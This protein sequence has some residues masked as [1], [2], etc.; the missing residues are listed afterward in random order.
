MGGPINNLEDVNRTKH[1]AAAAALARGHVPVA[2]RRR[3]H[4]IGQSPH[5]A[6]IGSTKH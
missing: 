6:K 3:A 5:I 2:L 1:A 4:R